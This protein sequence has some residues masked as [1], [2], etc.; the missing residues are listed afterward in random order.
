M[1]HNMTPEDLGSCSILNSA[2]FPSGGRINIIL[3]RNGDGKHID[4]NVYEA[5]NRYHFSLTSQVT[6]CRIWPVSISG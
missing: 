2:V 4:S 1:M 5:G 3:D 6:D